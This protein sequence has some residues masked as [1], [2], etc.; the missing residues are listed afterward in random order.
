MKRDTAHSDLHLRQPR[1]S[2]D[3]TGE[4]P[5][6]KLDKFPRSFKKPFHEAIEPRFFIVLVTSILLHVGLIVYFIQH[7]LVK[8]RESLSQKVRERFARLLLEGKEGAPGLPAE[9]DLT[10]IS[11]AYE[12]LRQDF[13]LSSAQ[14]PIDKLLDVPKAPLVEQRLPSAEE[15]R[16]ERVRRRVERRR[17]VERLTE[18]A[19]RVGLLGVL[20]TSTGNV[21]LRE[22]AD[23]LSEADSAEADLEQH[24]AFL[25]SLRVPRRFDVRR[26]ASL[27][28]ADWP[29]PTTHYDAS[30]DPGEIRGGRVRAQVAA[31]EMVAELADTKAVPV[32]KVARFEAVPSSYSL[33]GLA[34]RGSNGNGYLLPKTRDPRKVRE[35]VLSH[36]SAIQDCYNRE[37]RNHPG[38]KGKVVV[39]FVV[40]PE[41]RV[42]DA[43]IVFST[44]D[45]PEMLDCIVSRVMRWND[46]PPIQPSAGNM[47]IKQTYVFGY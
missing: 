37:L 33:D 32:Q 16:L 36:Y 31:E 21:Y 18:N 34:T 46:F 44:I 25:T 30:P 3:G 4:A 6:F 39:R 17:M 35:V 20:T 10:A 29:G 38:L 27:A 28:D 40:S 41:G 24:F 47:A 14:Q 45:H 9:E 43:K 23:I 1:R 15:R 5:I 19:E 8:D 22:I 12:L 2:G 7:P 26:Y 42:I 13:T 11:E